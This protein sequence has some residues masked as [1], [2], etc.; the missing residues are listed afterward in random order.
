MKP[1]SSAT[2]WASRP[3]FSV[4]AA[5]PT[6]TSRMSAVSERASPP[7]LGSTVISTRSPVFFAEVSLWPASSWMPRR[8]NARAVE[9]DA[10]QRAGARAGREDD[11]LGLDDGRAAGRVDLDPVRLPHAGAREQR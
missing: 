4:L 10:G 2:L 3:R 9:R 11:V 8:S 6:A 7:A 5:T 1:R